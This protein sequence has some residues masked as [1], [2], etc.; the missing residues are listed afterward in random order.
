MR[1]NKG[2]L[3]QLAGEGRKDQ[4]SFP[5]RR[6]IPIRLDG[7]AVAWC[8]GKRACDAERIARSKSRG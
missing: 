5:N 6:E 7:E 1:V 3:T 2:H 4:D 8:K